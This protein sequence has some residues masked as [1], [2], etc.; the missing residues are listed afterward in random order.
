MPNMTPEK[1]T[2]LAREIIQQ[3]ADR[4]LDKSHKWPEGWD[5][6][7]IRAMLLQAAGMEWS[8]WNAGQRKKE[9]A[10]EILVSNLV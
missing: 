2:E 6:R 9:V 5:G 4:V 3:W 7:D 1:Q 8:Q 10:N